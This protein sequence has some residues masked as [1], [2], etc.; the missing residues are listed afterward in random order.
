MYKICDKIHF[1]FHRVAKSQ[2]IQL[3]NVFFQSHVAKYSPYQ[4][5]YF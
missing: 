3:A 4:N 2:T 5:I 1:R